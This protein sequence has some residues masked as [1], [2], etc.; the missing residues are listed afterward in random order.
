MKLYS[1]V[2]NP[3]QDMFKNALVMI[4]TKI[5][6]RRELQASKK[7][8]KPTAD[9]L[10]FL[11]LAGRREI[12]EFVLDK[13]VIASELSTR[14][15]IDVSNWTESNQKRSNVEQLEEV[16]AKRNIKTFKV[17]VKRFYFGKLFINHF[18]KKF[19]NLCF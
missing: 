7:L 17:L 4:Q 14:I 8:F 12:Y 9:K 2:E 18:H 5:H 1:E 10:V 19:I 13:I 15:L 3:T 16:L 6:R 11:A